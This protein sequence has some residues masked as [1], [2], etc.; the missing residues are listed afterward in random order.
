MKTLLGFVAGVLVA[1]LVAVAM[2]SDSRPAVA[3]PPPDVVLAQPAPGPGCRP[4]IRVSSIAWGDRDDIEDEVKTPAYH[5][6]EEEYADAKGNEAFERMQ[7][8]GR[9]LD[10]PYAALTVQ[11]PL[12]FSPV[13]LQFAGSEAREACATLRRA[14]MAASVAE[15]LEGG[16]FL[17]KNAN[18]RSASNRPKFREY[19]S[20]YTRYR[21]GELIENHQQLTHDQAIA[22]LYEFKKF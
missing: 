17:A 12:Y 16:I 19:I 13:D 18:S 2:R 20:L 21:N 8:L 3:V 15:I 11:L 9:Q 7:A 4:S 14:G 5:Q 10:A 1:S 6:L 22:R